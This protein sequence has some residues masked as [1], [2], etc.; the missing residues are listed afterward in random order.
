MLH[1]HDTGTFWQMA[2]TFPQAMKVYYNLLVINSCKSLP[3]PLNIADHH[4]KLNP[5]MGACKMLALDASL[6]TICS[7]P[8]ACK[9]VCI[10][11]FITS[12]FIRHFRLK[13]TMSLDVC[14]GNL[15][16][17]IRFSQFSIDWGSYKISR[18][19]C[20]FLIDSLHTSSFTTPSGLTI[21]QKLR[22]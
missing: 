20:H 22:S 3:L 4:Q 9:N 1:C 19:W 6:D 8:G 18:N 17:F 12:L 16:R 10:K 5:S 14:T 15:I 2:S 7:S 11:S 21:G 13:N